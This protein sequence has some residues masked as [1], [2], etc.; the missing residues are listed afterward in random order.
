MSQCCHHVRHKIS[1]CSWKFRWL[2]KMSLIW[3][4]PPQI[5]EAS[6]RW[7]F[8]YSGKNHN[9]FRAYRI[10]TSQMRNR[11]HR[12]FMYRSR[13]SSVEPIYWRLK[14]W[15]LVN[16]SQNKAYVNVL[17][18][19]DLPVVSSQASHPAGKVKLEQFKSLNG[20]LGT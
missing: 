20:D 5:H 11:S 4:R 18:G 13:K 1:V 19:S 7:Q 12:T 8:V 3:V 15:K 17:N 6:M 14:T 9:S 10:E 16:I 2:R